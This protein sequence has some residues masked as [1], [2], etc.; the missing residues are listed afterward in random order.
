MK[1]TQA[2]VRVIDVALVNHLG[3]VRI[4]IWTGPRDV[5]PI[6]VELVVHRGHH[7]ARKHVSH[8]EDERVFVV[9]R[10]SSPPERHPFIHSTSLQRTPALL[11]SRKRSHPTS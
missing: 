11:P 10:S 5:L 1:L 8:H 6:A 7:L 2:W 4:R 9:A 3:V